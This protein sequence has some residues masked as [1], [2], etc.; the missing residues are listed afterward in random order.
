MIGPMI[1]PV[2]APKH[3][4]ESNLFACYNFFNGKYKDIE[5]VIFPDYYF[6]RFLYPT[7]CQI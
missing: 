7:F 4:N 2:D 1:Q 3:V 5:K 6:V